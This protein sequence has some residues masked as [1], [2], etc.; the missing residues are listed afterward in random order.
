MQALNAHL[1]LGL[2]GRD[3][4]LLC[5]KVEN[6]IVGAPCGVMDQMASALGREGEL[7]ALLCRPATVCVLTPL[8]LLFVSRTQQHLYI[9]HTRIKT[10]LG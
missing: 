1:A 10:S 5:Q 4:A 6:C 2:G 3:L 7:L 9:I 8:Q